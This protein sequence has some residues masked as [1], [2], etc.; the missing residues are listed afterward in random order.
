M[1]SPVSKPSSRL[2]AIDALRG[3][4]MLLMLLDHVRE[5]FYMHAQ[6]DDPMNMVTT[7]PGLFFTRWLAHFC[8]PIFIL[9]TGISAYLYGARQ[10][11]LGACPRQSASL[12]LLKRGLMLV[13]MELTIVNAGWSLTLVPTMLYLQV[14]WAIGLS[15]VALSALLWLPKRVLLALVAMIIIGHNALDGVHAASDSVWYIPWAILHDRCIIDIGTLHAR[16]SY[17]ILPWIAVIAL[18][19]CLGG[20][21]ER[22][23][24]R[25][26]RENRLLSWGMS[27]IFATL[28][29]RTLN[30]YGDHPWHIQRSALETTMSLLN[31]TKYPPSL[32]FLG[33]TL[34]VA[35]I[36]LYFFE[37]IPADR[38]INRWLSTYGS[39]P[40]FFYIF[41]LWV[42]KL[43][44]VLA[45]HCWG[46]NHGL[47]FGV[48]AVWMLWVITLILALLFYPV[49]DR[50]S[51][52]KA[53]HRGVCGLSY[54]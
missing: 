10:A 12:F 18:G 3:L 47:Y 21:F 40:L 20:W 32:L 34:S 38:R 45:V 7:P 16:T 39:V 24:P 14:I 30:C 28:L 1:M 25:D 50:F 6:V 26:A 2:H 19:Y 37:S 23:V 15:M 51:T 27:G 43:L 17:P 52:F 5:I 9:L 4:V 11:S 8:A 54:F 41:H 46:L 44:Y 35:L 49:V 53:K 33:L 42:L 29:L 48:S 13:I 31:F 36:L 22:S